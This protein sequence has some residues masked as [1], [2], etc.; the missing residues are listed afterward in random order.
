MNEIT[1]RRFVFAGYA[2]LERLGYVARGFAHGSLRKKKMEK[3]ENN[4]VDVTMMQTPVRFA[5]RDDITRDSRMRIISFR[6]DR[7]TRFQ[8]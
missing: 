3:R 1:P 8:I 2:R 5:N 7:I 4:S 6:S